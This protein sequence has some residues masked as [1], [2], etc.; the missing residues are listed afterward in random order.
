MSLS[1]SDTLY[2]FNTLW[3]TA[4]HCWPNRCTRSRDNPCKPSGNWGTE[5]NNWM[6]CCYQRHIRDNKRP[7]AFLKDFRSRWR[8]HCIGWSPRQRYLPM[9]WCCKYCLRR[10]HYCH[11]PTK[12]NT[13]PVL[14]PQYIVLS[15]KISEKISST[16]YR[17]KPVGPAVVHWVVASIVSWTE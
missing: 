15:W 11:S 1:C 10:P 12:R 2:Q 14:D 3:K 4:Y 16:Q 9:C 13:L 7:F 8:L 17:C 6:P 5:Q